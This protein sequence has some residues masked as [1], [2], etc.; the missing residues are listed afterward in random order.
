MTLMLLLAAPGH[1][2]STSALPFYT[3][4]PHTMC[5]TPT[6]ILHAK[7]SQ[8]RVSAV[9]MMGRKKKVVEEEVDD[10]DSYVEEAE[11][12]RYQ[13]VDAMTT[14]LGKDEELKPFPGPAVRM[15]EDAPEDGR[16]VFC[17]FGLFASGTMPSEGLQEQYYAWLQ[18]GDIPGNASLMGP[19]YLLS[20]E[21]DDDESMLALADE[22]DD[23]DIARLDAEEEA[24]AAAAEAEASEDEAGDEV[25]GEIAV[26]EAPPLALES[27]IEM[28]SFGAQFVL[29]HLTLARAPS[30]EVAHAW[31]E[32]DP[33]NVLGGYGTA[34]QLHQWLVSDDEALNVPQTGEMTQSYAVHCLDKSGATDLR[35]S[36]RDKHLD[37]LRA[38]GRVHMGG[39]LLDAAGVAPDANPMGAGERV[40]TLLIVSGESLEEVRDWAKSDPYAGA[41]L[42]DS[43]TVAPLNTYL[44]D[45]AVLVD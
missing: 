12:D 15:E 8:R 23:D 27:P 6:A 10:D 41:G 24:A 28:E 16:A 5:L 4:A 32:T 13:M 2:V 26:D 17:H 31:V 36:T 33:V 21:N 29:G 22:L 45:Y 37:W 14:S 40:G 38:S 25:D 3:S 39:P 43:V 19:H 18:Q 44:V 35:A 34:A 42:F 9:Q 20:G 11:E 1:T 7:A 30:W